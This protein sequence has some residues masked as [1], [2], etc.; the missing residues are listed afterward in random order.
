MEQEIAECAR[1]IE[2]MKARAKYFV[3]CP[4]CTSTP[5]DPNHMVALKPCHHVLCDNCYWSLATHGIHP[6]PKI[7]WCNREQNGGQKTK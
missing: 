5:E 7:P 4:I 2:E 6:R 1:R 3:K